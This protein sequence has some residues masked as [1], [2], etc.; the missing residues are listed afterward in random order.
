MWRQSHN[1]SIRKRIMKHQ[2]Q[3][4]EAKIMARMER[5][6]QAKTLQSFT[7]AL[8]SHDEDQIVKALNAL[9]KAGKL[10]TFTISYTSQGRRSQVFWCLP[11]DK[12]NPPNN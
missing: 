5:F 1:R 11:A 9:V 12:P 6:R 8:N 4:I 7:I 2:Q 10:A 3:Q